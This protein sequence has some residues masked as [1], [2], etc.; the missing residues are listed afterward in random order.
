M[1]DIPRRFS[2]SQNPPFVSRRGDGKDW[3]KPV[4]LMLQVERQLLSKA[5]VQRVSA[6]RD[7][8]LGLLQTEGK[9][10]SIGG[11]PL[12]G[13]TQSLQTSLRFRRAGDAGGTARRL[14]WRRCRRSH[15]SAR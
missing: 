6:W 3:D 14:E 1:Q 2:R 8:A 12:A 15:R 7:V 13:V 10:V 5:D 11:N 9:W 4:I